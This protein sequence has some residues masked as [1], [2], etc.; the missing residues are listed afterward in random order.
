VTIAAAVLPDTQGERGGVTHDEHAGSDI[1]GAY[2][3]DGAHGGAG[4]LVL[5]AVRGVD[6]AG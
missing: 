6:A 3:V 5:A 4:M 1:P 2:G